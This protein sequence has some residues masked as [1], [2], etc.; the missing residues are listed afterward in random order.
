[1]INF[2]IP[3][4]KASVHGLLIGF[5]LMAI[6]PF[7]GNMTILTY[8][9]DIFESS[10]SSIGANESSMII[11]F[12]QFVGIYI[13]SMYVD[14]FGRKILMSISCL[15]SGLSLLLIAS[16]SYVS[17]I[18]EVPSNLSWIPIF[19]L[20]LTILLNSIGISSLPFIIVTEL[21]PQKV[22]NLELLRK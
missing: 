13:A 15:G 11:G 21:V 14:K 18:L 17:S 2:L 6:A 20:S 16:Y 19:S 8:T 9:S 4:E 10:G 7:S 12:I 1:M 22:S 3:A 5:F